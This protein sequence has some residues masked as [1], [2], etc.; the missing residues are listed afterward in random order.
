[1][2][3]TKNALVILTVS[4]LAP[5]AHAGLLGTIEEQGNVYSVYAENTGPSTTSGFDTW[6]LTWS[7]DSS[8]YDAS[9]F[10]DAAN[11]YLVGAS[12]K[13]RLDGSAT[14]QDLDLTSAPGATSDWG[15]ALLELSNGGGGGCNDNSGSGAVCAD[16]NDF[17]NPVSESQ[18][19]GTLS[20]SFLIDITEG[21][22][23]IGAAVKALWWNP[24]D[25][26]G[27][28]P[29]GKKVGSL[30]SKDVVRVPEPGTMTLLGAGLI[31]LVLVRRKRA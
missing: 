24:T 6:S 22:D 18:I 31:G 14:T 8:G 21:V 4:V 30:V 13:L 5:M 25:T 20:L 9:V 29:D 2:K 11:T 7:V 27:G 17:A 3:Y 12:I 19:G 23:V 15:E 28:H 1:M 26:N 10:T 16:Q